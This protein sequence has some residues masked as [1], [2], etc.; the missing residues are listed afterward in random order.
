MIRLLKIFI[1]NDIF[2]RKNLPDQNNRRFYPRFKILRA[3]MCRAMKTLRESVIDQ[4]L[5]QLN[6][7]RQRT[8]VQNY[9][10]V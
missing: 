8:Q 7:R 6:N 3:A 9:N 4:E 2:D 10:S 1:K 5:L